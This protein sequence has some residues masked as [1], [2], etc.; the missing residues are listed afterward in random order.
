MNAALNCTVKSSPDHAGIDS[1]A[2]RVVARGEIDMA[3]A[4]LLTK[5]FNS[6]IDQG[7][8]VVVVDATDVT[9]VDSA[10]LR[11][12]VTAANR[13]S[14]AGGHLFIEGMSGAVRAVLEISGLLERYRA[15]SPPLDTSRYDVATNA[16]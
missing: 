5:T 7:A 12:I 2:Y 1:H 9:F 8:T 15:P 11:A 3:S 16:T 6:V 14:E 13:V 4:P 10:G